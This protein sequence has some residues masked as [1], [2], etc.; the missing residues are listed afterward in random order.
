VPAATAAAAAAAAVAAAAVESHEKK[1]AKAAMRRRERLREAADR[2]DREHFGDSNPD[3]DLLR[4]P[5][6]HTLLRAPAQH[7]LQQRRSDQDG[8]Y[9]VTTVACP[10]PRCLCSWCSDC[11][12]CVPWRPARC[13][14]AVG[15]LRGAAALRGVTMSERFTVRCTVGM[16]VARGVA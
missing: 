4:C 16:S 8:G 5:D 11:G 1:E 9:H 15:V 14:V 6:C 10:D 13:C 12:E 3:G 2:R 7:Q